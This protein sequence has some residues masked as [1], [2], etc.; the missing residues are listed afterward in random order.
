MRGA[1]A[2]PG[3]GSRRR[4]EAAEPE[5]AVWPLRNSFVD[6]IVLPV[7]ILSIG[8]E[9]QVRRPRHFARR[10]A[11]PSYAAAWRLI[12]TGL[13]QEGNGWPPQSCSAT[14]EARPCG[15]PR[16][17]DSKAT[18]SRSTARAGASFSSRSGAERG[19]GATGRAGARRRATC[20]C[21]SLSRRAEARSIWTIGEVS[22]RH[23][24]LYLRSQAA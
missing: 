19:P 21:P 9:C 22:P 23:E 15:S 17:F 6:L 11:A 14:A 13:D 7:W 8:D 4:R 2:E 24:H 18:R 16:S 12:Y 1:P 20:K 10:L 3:A 5:D